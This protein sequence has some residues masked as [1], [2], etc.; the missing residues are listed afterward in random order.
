MPRQSKGLA[1]CL[2]GKTILSCGVSLVVAIG[3]LS[4]PDAT[5]A[6]QEDQVCNGTLD[7]ILPPFMDK[8]R[9]WHEARPL[10]AQLAAETGRELSLTIAATESE[11]VTAFA[12]GRAD[13]GMFSHFA[14][15]SAVETGQ[16]EALA[17]T[18]GWKVSA[19]VLVE[20][21]I[22]S[23]RDKR[24]QS[25]AAPVGTSAAALARS[26]QCEIARGGNPV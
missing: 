11:T 22:S 16:A 12:K 4:A 20:S 24:I 26:A 25:V 15:K 3:V 2:V 23:L 17:F 19:W 21:P 1:I 7:A 9:L 8:A 14:A 13:I 6:E 18:N 10:F 5:S